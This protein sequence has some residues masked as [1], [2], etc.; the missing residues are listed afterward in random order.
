[1]L[2]SQEL[3]I[4]D[5]GGMSN[6]D[7]T[8]CFPPWMIPLKGQKVLAQP[9]WMV[10]SCGPECEARCLSVDECDVIYRTELPK[11]GNAIS[12]ERFDLKNITGLTEKEAAERLKEE[13]YNE[14]PS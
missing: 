5:V 9:I 1:M 6:T 4:A 11:E 8:G 14:L 12:V 10:V 2:V 13:G 3:R 7:T